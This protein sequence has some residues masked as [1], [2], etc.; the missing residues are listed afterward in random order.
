[1]LILFW[2][3]TALIREWLFSP[4]GA[5]I[6]YNRKGSFQA[7]ATNQALATKVEEKITSLKTLKPFVQ[8]TGNTFSE[9]KLFNALVEYNSGKSQIFKGLCYNEG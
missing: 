6:S 8:E 1:M 9:T 5:L 4:D 2:A 7:R 3:L